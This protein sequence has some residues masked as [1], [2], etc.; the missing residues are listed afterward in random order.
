MGIYT[1]PPSGTQQQFLLRHGRVIDAEQVLG[2]DFYNATELPVAYIVPNSGHVQT[3][4]FSA[5]EAEETAPY[6]CDFE[7]SMVVCNAQDAARVT[8]PREKRVI[9]FYAIPVSVLIDP[10]LGQVDPDRLR[11]YRPHIIDGILYE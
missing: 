4:V 9:I 6:L 8:D 1:G 3:T 11:A 2:W 5:G 7:A 10:A